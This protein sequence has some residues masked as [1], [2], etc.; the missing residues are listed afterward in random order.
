MDKN[1]S[2]LSSLDNLLDLYDNAVEQEFPESLP[3]ITLDCGYHICEQ[4]PSIL[5]IFASISKHEFLQ[6]LKVNHTESQSIEKSTGKQRESKEWRE[7]TKNRLTSTSANK[8]FI[9]KKTLI[10][11][12]NK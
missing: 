5:V 10:N 9:R 6:K 3:V 1:F 7:H 2:I 12:T 8:I 11:Y 4:F